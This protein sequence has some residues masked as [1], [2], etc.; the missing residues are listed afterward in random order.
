[1]ARSHGAVDGWPVV[2]LDGGA[3]AFAAEVNVYGKELV[4][5][6]NCLPGG[7]ERLAARSEGSIGRIDTAGVELELR[8]W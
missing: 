5:T 1:M 8:A 6:I 3:A 4:L 2:A 7:D